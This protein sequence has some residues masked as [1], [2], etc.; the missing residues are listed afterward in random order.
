V[1]R[2]PRLRL[3]QGGLANRPVDPES[4]GLEADLRRRRG[5][6]AT[7]WLPEEAAR[8]RPRHLVVIS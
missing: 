5:L 4:I 2:P 3:I 1:K 6:A 8:P 7:D